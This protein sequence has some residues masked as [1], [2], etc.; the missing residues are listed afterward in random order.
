MKRTRDVLE[1]RNPYN[2]CEKYQQEIL[3]DMDKLKTPDN[4]ILVRNVINRTEEEFLRLSIEN[5][6]NNKLNM[7]SI[8]I[9][10]MGIAVSVLTALMTF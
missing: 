6:K 8:A 10:I 9:G 4:E 5:K 3:G 7:I 1:K 2:K